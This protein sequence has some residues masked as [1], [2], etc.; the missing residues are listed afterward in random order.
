M[1]CEICGRR[2]LGRPREKLVEGVKLLVCDRCASRDDP[3]WRPPIKKP[4]PKLASKVG[5]KKPKIEEEYLKF[6]FVNDYNRKVKEAREKLG[7]TQEG[8]AKKL[9]EKASV[10]QKIEAGRIVPD[11][12]LAKELERALRIRILTS[13]ESEAPV[14]KA[15]IDKPPLTLGDLARIKRKHGGVQS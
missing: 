10:I 15:P 2:I 7:L 9:K 12:R 11:L 3:Y 5:W 14:V 13:S 4:G 6:D 1:N 8:L